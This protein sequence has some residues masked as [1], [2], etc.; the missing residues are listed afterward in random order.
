M[1]LGSTEALTRGFQGG[2]TD[3]IIG[4]IDE[5]SLSGGQAIVIAAVSY[6]TNMMSWSF[7]QN[8]C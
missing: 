8:P 6:L 5:S 7:W 4:N 1:R 2:H 3:R